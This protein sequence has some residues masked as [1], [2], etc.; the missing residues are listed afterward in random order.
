MLHKTSATTVVQPSAKGR[1]DPCRGGCDDDGDD[2]D[3][4]D[5]DYK[6]DDDHDDGD[7]AMMMMMMTSDDD[8]DDMMVTMTIN[9][10]IRMPSSSQIMISEWY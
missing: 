5:D 4:D 9:S 7:D 3:D 2:A 1:V 10:A 6:D 8:E